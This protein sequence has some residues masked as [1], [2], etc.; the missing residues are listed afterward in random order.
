[1]H[2]EDLVLAGVDGSGD[3]PSLSYADSFIYVTIAH[4]TCYQADSVSGLKEILEP[5]PAIMEFSWIPEDTARGH[6]A[7]NAAFE[8]MVGV[9]IAEI[10]KQSDYRLFKAN[11]S[12]KSNTIGQL[13]TGLIRPHAS[14]SGNIAIQ[15]C[16]TGELATVLQLIRAERQLDYV[17][18]DG[19][20]SLPFVNRARNSLFH[21]HLKRL[22]C[23]EARNRRIG[24]FALS[25][26]HGLP[27]IEHI[28]HLAAEALNLDARQVAEH[29][30]FRLPV[31]KRDG[32]ELKLVE[33]HNLPP[34]GT[35]T[36]LV[37]FHRNVPVMR[38]DMDEVYWQQSVQGTNDEETRFNERRMFEDLD[39][40]SHDQRQRFILIE[41]TGP[42]NEVRADILINLEVP[43]LVGI[44]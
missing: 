18:Y 8:R 13:T 31:Y 39:Y 9:S 17:L 10:I 25:K 19:T 3:Y 1:V 27:A 28:E 16:S 15:F 12:G 36:Y 32:W 34:P 26:S 24:F 22:C 4:G 6:E 38:L 11:F 29:W 30:Y 21:E 35:V 33:Q 20:L 43:A 40:A 2:R 41:L 23:V 5:V 37:R 7:I 14:D 42:L 44:S